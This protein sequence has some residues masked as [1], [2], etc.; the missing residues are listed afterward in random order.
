MRKDNKNYLTVLIIMFLIAVA[1]IVL[2]YLGSKVLFYF[3]NEIT[4][5]VVSNPTVVI[6]TPYGTS[7]MAP[8]AVHAYALDSNLGA[9]TP[10]TATYEWDFGDPNG[11]YNKLRGW[12]VAHVYD[13]SGTSALYVNKNNARIGIGTTTPA[14]K[15][16]VAGTFN[17]TQGTTSLRVTSDNNILIH[18]E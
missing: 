12:N 10:L 17:A 15:L 4:G 13:N 18:L 6:T 16:E 1:V 2:F 7:G 3:G 5:R 8:F 11:K 14:S 9:G